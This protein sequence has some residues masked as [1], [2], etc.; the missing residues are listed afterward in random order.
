MRAVCIGECMASCGK[1]IKPLRAGLRRRRLQRRRLSEALGAAGACELPH[2]DRRVYAQ[3]RD[4][5][6]LRRRGGEDA[7][8]FI[9]KDRE[10]GLY[11]I[12]LNAAGER[13]F[14]YW[15]SS[16]AARCWLQLLMQNGGAARLAGTDLVCLSGVSLAILPDDEARAAAIELLGSLKDRVGKIAFD[17]NLRPSLWRN[18][19][20]ARA[21]IAPMIRLADVFRASGEDAALLTGAREPE[22]QIGALRAG[23]AHEIVLTLGAEGCI[24][25]TKDGATALP[26]L[27]V[28]VKDTSGAGDA[29]TGAYLAAR[30]SGAA[31]VDAAAAALKVAS[32]VVTYPGAIAPREISHPRQDDA[33]NHRRPRHRHLPG[34][35]L[36][37]PK[38]R[39][40]RRSARSRRRHLN[41]RELAVASYLTGHIIQL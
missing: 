25:A 1:P 7:L 32:R 5:R 4:A 26:A 3:P 30:L 16:S 28:E 21:A 41:G 9:A 38:D 18:L 17:A 14:H 8:A 37:H 22:T 34:A 13:R 10:I 23:G 19:D 11:M 12:E 2:R 15:R 29:F 6:A 36:R 33:E 24:V 31:P 40:A 20:A 35:Q 27:Y 39:D